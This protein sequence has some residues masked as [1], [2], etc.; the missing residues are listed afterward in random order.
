[1]KAIAILDAGKVHLGLN[2]FGRQHVDIGDSHL[3]QACQAEAVKRTR[4]AVGADDATSFCVDQQDGQAQALEQRPV[5]PLAARKF[6]LPALQ[7][8]QQR[9]DDQRERH[10]QRKSQQHQPPLLRLLAVQQRQFGVFVDGGHGDQRPRRQPLP[11]K[12]Q[13]HLVH[14]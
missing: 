11:G 8:G 10:H 12:C 7:A 6:V 1:M 2:R 4:R 13:R 5:P 3:L 9:S 14:G